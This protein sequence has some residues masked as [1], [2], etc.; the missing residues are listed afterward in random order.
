MKNF[1]IREFPKSRIATVDV[2]AIGKQRHHMCVLLECDVT[3]SRMKITALKS[4]GTRI[5]FTAWLLKVIG[6]TL[7]E[8]NE[9]AAFLFGRKKVIVFDDINISLLVEKKL[10]GKKVPIP[11]VIEKADQKSITE[12]TKEIEDAKNE[13]LPDE[14][15][16]LNRR[17][18]FPEKIYY[19]MPG[20]LRRIIWKVMLKFPKSLYRK[21]GN[22][23]FTSVGMFG[24]IKGWFIHTTIHPV[25]FG[26]G[27]I[28]KKPLVVDNEIK[29]REVL[30]MTIL[31]DHDVIDGAPI[32]RFVND[33]VKRI[34]GGCE[35]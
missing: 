24:Q 32:V 25:S 27:S 29:I 4:R 13:A 16:V 34:E 22:A 7:K 30:N 15:I 26:V 20:Y 6:K 19:Y 5:S 11:L 21:M 35:L 10:E 17:I 23:A 1:S 33:L 8:H 9:A 12:I 28:V 31:L 18:S 3:E 14:S 2:V